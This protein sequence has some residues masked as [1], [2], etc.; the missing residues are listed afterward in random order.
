MLL[1]CGVVHSFGDSLAASSCMIV[2]TY[3]DVVFT[4]LVFGKWSVKKSYSVI[5]IEAILCQWQGT[6][7]SIVSGRTR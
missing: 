1:V 2:S 4:H 3:Y 7:S 6:G 5:E